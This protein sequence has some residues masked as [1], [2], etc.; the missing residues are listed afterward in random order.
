MCAWC[1]CGW[2]EAGLAVEKVEIVLF[3]VIA[4][5]HGPAPAPALAPAAAPPPAVNAPVINTPG[6]VPAVASSVPVVQPMAAGSPAGASKKVVI[7]SVVS[8]V[9]ATG[10]S[11]LP[12]ALPCSSAVLQNAFLW[13]QSCCPG[14]SL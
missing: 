12:R 4:N 14:L 8:V 6:P 5:G 10:G 7:A 1:A 13:A 3:Q 9:A 2:G 11:S